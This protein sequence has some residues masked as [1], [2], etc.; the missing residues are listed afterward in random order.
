MATLLADPPAQSDGQGAQPA[1]ALPAPGAG[2]GLQH[3]CANCGAPL[4]PGQDWCLQCGAGTPG[5]LQADGN[6]WRATAAVLSALA[7]LVAGAAAAAYAAVSKSSAKPRPQVALVR[8]SAPAASAPL[9]PPPATTVTPAPAIPKLTAPTVKPSVPLVKATTPLLGA[10]TKT[11]LA[12]TTPA[13]TTGATKT[14]TG[15]GSTTP[16]AKGPAALTLDTNAA[17]TYN[18]YSYAAGNFG[19]PSLAIDGETATAWTAQVE[20]SVAPRMAVGLLIDLKTPQR[21]SA[22]ALVTTTPGMAV[23]VY[24]AAGQAAPASITDPAWKRLSGQLVVKK[25]TTR[26]SLADTKHAFRFVTLWISKA[27]SSAVITPE[28]PGHVR[29]NELELFPAA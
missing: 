11:P 16:A 12:A 13:T 9:T 24:G 28:A 8:I 25:R 15:G 1:P 29:V 14:S 18:P 23:Q 22:L 19:D 10:G 27:P 4:A 7:L 3:G 20:A 6:R 21:L 5:S 17:S 2:V 26:V